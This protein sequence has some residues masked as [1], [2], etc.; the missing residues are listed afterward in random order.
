MTLLQFLLS[1]F[2]FTSSDLL[3]HLSVSDNQQHLQQVHLSKRSDTRDVRT[4]DELL[5]EVLQDLHP[6]APDQQPDLEGFTWYG[7][8]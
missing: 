6:L 7:Y 3:A 4:K 2:Q 5:H 8:G 1:G